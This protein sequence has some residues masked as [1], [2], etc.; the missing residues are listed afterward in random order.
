M[1]QAGTDSGNFS[2]L[3]A[4]FAVGSNKTLMEEE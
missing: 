2:M 4:V 1:S 3:T